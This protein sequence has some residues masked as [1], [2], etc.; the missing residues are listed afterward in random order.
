MRTKMDLHLSLGVSVLHLMNVLLS[1]PWSRGSYYRRSHIVSPV[2]P[3]RGPACGFTSFFAHADS[4]RVYVYVKARLA[5]SAPFPGVGESHACAKNSRKPSIG[6]GSEFCGHVLPP[7]QGSYDVAQWWVLEFVQNV[8]G[9]RVLQRQ[10]VGV[11]HGCFSC[12]NCVQTRGIV[13][14]NRF[15][16]GVLVKSGC[17]ER[18]VECLRGVAFMTA[19]AVLG[20]PCPLFDCPTKI[21][22]REATMTIL[23]VLVVSAVMAVSVVTATPLN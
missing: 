20:A 19:L 6:L 9:C 14:T 8:L 12:S 2:T 3:V 7:W 16:Q 1:C 18:G 4:L 21:Q 22:C 17:R 11:S 23:T 5:N 10:L 15:T 13:K